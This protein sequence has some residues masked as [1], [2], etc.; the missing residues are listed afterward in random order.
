VK[1]LTGKDA[2][3]EDVERHDG[4]AALGAGGDEA[5]VVVDAEVM[6]EPHHR[7]RAA[8]LGGAAGDEEALAAAAEAALRGRRGEEAVVVAEAEREECHG[9]RATAA[10][11]AAAI[12]GGGA[13]IRR[14][15]LAR[16]HGEVVA[17]DGRGLV[18][19]RER[20]LWTGRVLCFLWRR[21]SRRLV[22]SRRG[23]LVFV[24]GSTTQRR[25]DAGRESGVFVE[26][27]VGFAGG[28]NETKAP[29]IKKVR[30]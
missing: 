10:A 18:G 25:R 3:V 1:Q 13:G 6:L 29:S 11:A 28:S 16:A 21:C 30:G 23:V 14:A 5:R 19:E 9:R 26:P 12:G 27:L 4:A 22:V 7:G 17:E 24:P 15:G 20:D 2:A 8:R